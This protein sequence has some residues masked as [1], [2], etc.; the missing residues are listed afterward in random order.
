MVQWSLPSTA[1][2]TQAALRESLSTGDRLLEL[3]S[4]EEKRSVV[5]PRVLSEESGAGDEISGA[6]DQQQVTRKSSLN[7]RG[8]ETH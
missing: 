4:A 8:A 7:K 1:A 5:G 6:P 3:R 2:L